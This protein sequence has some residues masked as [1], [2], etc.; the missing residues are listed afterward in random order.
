MGLRELFKYA[1]IAAAVVAVAAC[2]APDDSLTGSQ[3]S[4]QQRVLR[5]GNGGEPQTLDPAAA[6]DIHSFAVLTDLY[7][8]L[9][10]EAGDGSLRPGVAERWDISPDGRQY[11]FYLRQ[12]AVWSTGEPVK[13]QHFVAEFRRVLAPGTTSVYAFLLEPIRN[14]QAVLSGKLPPEELGIQAIDNRTLIIELKSP[15]QHFLGIL[16]MP[17]AYPLYPGNNDDTRRFHNPVSFTGN[18][19]YVL[20][21]WSIGERIR[22]TK[23][24]RY[25]NAHSV[26]IETVE[27][28]PISD[29]YTELNMFRVGE[30][31]ITSTVPKDQIAE[32]RESRGDE[33]HIAPSLALYYLAFDLSEPPFDDVR[34]RQALTMAVDRQ[35]LVNVLGRGEQPAFGL[36][37]PGVANH[38]SARYSWQDMAATDR[39][40]KA[41]KL[42]E[43]WGYDRESPPRLKLTY[44]TGDVHETI[45]LSVT[46]MWRDVLG[47]E[48][49]M[50]KKEWKYF[51]ATRDDRPAWQIMRFAWS[52]DYNDPSTFTDIFRS[53]SEQNLPGYQN[54]DYDRLLDEANKLINMDERA[55]KISAA[56]SLL[57]DDYPIAPLYFYVS[58]HLVNGRVRNF[59]N[60]VLDRHPTQ[61]L[62]LQVADQK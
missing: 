38:V 3:D 43:Q 26:P 12:D 56:E 58:K 41:R 54:S 57:L 42:F 62:R 55:E 13:A 46:S 17:I 60:N 51:L 24:P 25:R 10:I 33:L 32:L 50:E 9:V 45:A 27:Y 20:E 37:P 18:G 44:D 21:S 1:L 23:N 22:L 29:P 53:G 15:A 47:I 61:F 49:E 14:Y 34:L 36:V 35:T 28:L 16:A 2:E 19:P 39:Q 52:G 7:E 31:D 40:A 30:L 48:V 5:R 8:G 59:E 11:T 6:E 4:D